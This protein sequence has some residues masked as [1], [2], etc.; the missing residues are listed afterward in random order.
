MNKEMMTISTGGTPV[1]T[2]EEAELL[3]IMALPSPVEDPEQAEWLLA[4]LAAMARGKAK[5]M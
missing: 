1:L 5:A 3:L 2:P 4:K